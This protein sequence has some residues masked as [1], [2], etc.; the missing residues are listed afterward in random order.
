VDTTTDKPHPIS[1]YTCA[2][3]YQLFGPGPKRALALDGGGVRGAI[4]VAFLE[5]MEA[6]FSE[7]YGR[8]VRLGNYFNLVGGTSTG[9]IIAG[10]LALGYRA[11]QV[12]EFYTALAP[13]AFKRQRWSIPFLHAKFDVRGLRNEIEKIVGDL[14][15]QSDELITGLCVVTKRIDTGSPWILA[16]NPAAP[17]WEDGRGHDGNKYYK[18]ATLVRASTAAPS[19]FDPEILP[20][21]GRKEKLADADA[22]PLE[23]PLPARFLQ[24][25][26]E[27]IGLRKKAV[28]S[29]RDYGLFIDGGVTQHNNPSF[30]LLQMISLTPFKLCWT[31]GPENLSVTSIGTGTYRPRIKYEDLGFTRYAQLALH[32]LMSMMTDAEMMVLA[33]MQWLGEC[34]A[35][36]VINSEIGTLAGNGPPGGK[37]FRFVRYDVKLERPW[38]LKELE[39]DVPEADVERFRCMDDP[40][41]VKSIYE[42]ASIA[43]ARQVK[44]EHFFPNAERKSV[45]AGVAASASLMAA[46]RNTALA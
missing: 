45:P 14:E 3:D 44:P 31:P 23:K 37:L 24:A 17:Y 2:R 25:L 43:A 30:A 33:Q 5:R 11:S 39:L 16:N 27:R 12:R 6:V 15:M 22:T 38:L 36:W 21:S 19:F 40:G 29:P 41:I 28:P 26:L 18:L 34:P 8:E 46:E 10:A 7:H 32:A 9:A 42:I 1:E 4:T 20:I 13:L 35:P